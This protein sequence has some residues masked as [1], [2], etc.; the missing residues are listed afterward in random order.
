MVL[1]AT[2]L[3]GI[4]LHAQLVA[5]VPRA[6]LPRPDAAVARATVH[7]N[8]VPAGRLTGN[9]QR[10]AIDVIESA[11]RPEG[12][13]DPEVP[14]LAFAE[15]GQG[16][17]VPGPLVR[18]RQGTEIVV[19]LRN[20]SDSAVVIG[21]LR[22]GI[23]NDTVQLAIGATREIRHRLDTPGTYLYW[24]AFKG[25]T[26]GDRFWKDSQL[27]GAL[28]VDPPGASTNDQILVL[29]EWFLLRDDGWRFEAA[30]AINGKGWPHTATIEL[31][32]GDSSRFRIVNAMAALEH[33]LHLH[34]FYYRIESHGD[35]ARD[36]AVPV[37]SQRLSNTDVI[38]AGGTVTFSFLASTP[39]NWLFHCHFA[40]HADE[41]V[42]IATP[43][44]S[45]GHSM[46]GLVMGIKVAPSPGYV[47][48]STADAREIQLYVGKRPAS[49]PTAAPAIGFSLR[50]GPG[51][52]ARD[53][54]VLPGPVLELRRNQPVRIVVNN[55]L[56]EPTSVHWHGLEIESYPDGVPHFSGLGSRIYQQVAPRDSFVAEFTPTR[57]GTFPYHSHLNDRHQI[58][59]G[60]Y[61]ALIVTDA[62]R[63]PTRDHLV[64]A[65][66]GGPEVFE[67]YESP[68]ALVNG[69]RNP[70][71]LRLTA[72]ETHRIRLVSIHPDWLISFSL[73]ND[74]SVARWRAIAKDGADL[75]PALATSRPANVTMGPGETADF[76][77]TP[78]A[79]GSWQLEVRS[80]VAGWYIP[81]RVNV[82]PAVPK[83]APR[84]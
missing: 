38:A 41:A 67:K 37:D 58:Q 30:Q 47:A 55:Q 52:P 29:S 33:P 44:G 16:P 18:V 83:G 12:V 3:L 56:D 13:D 2:A 32:Q 46:R 69:S 4:V 6:P 80:S 26:A 10:I 78:G 74:T 66:G 20:R 43:R 62:P 25:T 75:P 73:R 17:T 39:G 7:Q 45:S 59:S 1:P 48:A 81:L 15:A 8:R 68:Y 76:E 28:V 40:F 9:T 51:I 53:S 42:S 70:R 27:N 23:V 57:A 35:G 24:G 34:G 71:A 64:V 11:W 5:P 72:G 50:S 22:P 21:G 31:Q 63:D 77:F 84:E 60:L 79:P 19:T 82:L 61:G 65:G 54:V 14:I 49:L 36:I